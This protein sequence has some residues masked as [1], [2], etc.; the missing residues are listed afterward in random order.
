[1]DFGLTPAMVFAQRDP[2]DGQL[3]FIDELCADDLGAVRFAEDA[4][5][6]IRSHYRNRPISGHGD[7]AGDQRAQT[8]ERT[9]FDVVNSQGIPIGPAPTN[10]FTLRREAI[11]RALT[12]LT[13]LGRPALVVSPKCKR[14][15][16]AMNGGYHFKRVAAAGDDRFRDVPDKNEYS[17]VAEAAQYLAVG[18]GEDSRALESSVERRRVTLPFKTKRAFGRRRA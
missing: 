12:R 7:P 16:K 10:D 6:Y 17:H 4:A 8:D 2:R 9:P 15:R 13:M 1:M 14:L 3:Q 18:E 5:R 11:A